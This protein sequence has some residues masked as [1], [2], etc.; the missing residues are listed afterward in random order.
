LPQNEYL[1][2]HHKIMFASISIRSTSAQRQQQ[3]QQHIISVTTS[4]ERT[5][6]K[7]VVLADTIRTM[8]ESIKVRK[9]R[10]C[11]RSN[12]S[13]RSIFNKRKR[14]ARL[15][16]LE[17]ASEE[18]GTTFDGRRS[19]L[20]FSNEQESD[21]E[22]LET[23]AIGW[24]GHIGFSSPGEMCDDKKKGRLQK[25]KAFIMA[26]A[27]ARKRRSYFHHHR[28]SLDLVREEIEEN[29]VAYLPRDSHPSL[30]EFASEFDQQEFRHHE[31][32]PAPALIETKIENKQKEGVHV[33]PAQHLQ[34]HSKVEGDNWSTD[35]STVR[36]EEQKNEEEIAITPLPVPLQKDTVG[37]ALPA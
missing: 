25:L 6:S 37:Y 13:Q 27:N 2:K 11:L 3:Q 14:S 17:L 19:S 9:Q 16:S 1:L 26:R 7:Q 32:A 28:C 23:V 36:R 24:E 8:Q 35:V 4:I 18:S 29:N 33:L 30:R 31:D 21:I 20:F 15:T 5:A 34:S 22:H 10:T 12:S